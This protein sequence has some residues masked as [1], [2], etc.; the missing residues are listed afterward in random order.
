[1]TRGTGG[2]GFVD[3]MVGL[4]WTRPIE[5]ALTMEG[6]TVPLSEEEQRQFEQQNAQDFATP[7][8]EH[9]Q[10]LLETLCGHLGPRC[11]GEGLDHRAVEELLEPVPHV[12]K[13]RSVCDL[14]AIEGR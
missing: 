9:P 5:I 10:P 12:G 4:D 6:S 7:E 1:M 14:E 3:P 13:D 11:I 2:Q 8:A